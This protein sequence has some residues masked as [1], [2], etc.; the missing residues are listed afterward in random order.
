MHEKYA[1]ISYVL[2]GRDERIFKQ[3]EKIKQYML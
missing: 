1:I 3:K 2:E